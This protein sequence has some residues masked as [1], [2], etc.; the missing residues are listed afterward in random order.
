MEIFNDFY[1]K[2]LQALNEYSDNLQRELDRGEYS[3]ILRKEYTG[4]YKAVQ[5]EIALLKWIKS[6][7]NIHQKQM[8]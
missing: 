7:L 2:R 6:E 4:E 1:E 3:F 8:I 5:K